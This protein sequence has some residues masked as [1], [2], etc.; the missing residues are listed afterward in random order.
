MPIFTGSLARS[1]I[2][3][4]SERTCGYREGGGA[5]PLSFRNW[6]LERLQAACVLAGC[7]FLPSLKGI[8]FKKAHALL[9]RHRLLS[10]VRFAAVP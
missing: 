10:R 3:A 1:S 4:V 8:G 2:E 7:D 9:H 5:R 6:D